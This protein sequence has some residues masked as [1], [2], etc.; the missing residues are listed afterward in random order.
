MC[1]WFS[2]IV[3][4]A[5]HS[6]SLSPLRCGNGYLRPPVEQLRE[7]GAVTDFISRAD[8]SRIGGRRG[9]SMA[10]GNAIWFESNIGGR[11]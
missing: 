8:G 1:R 2:L 4:I 7:S 10:K 5:F 11:G 6:F 9:R 3:M